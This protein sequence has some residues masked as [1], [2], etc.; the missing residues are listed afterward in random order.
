MAIDSESAGYIEE[1]G[2]RLRAEVGRS[3]VGVYLHGSA[4]LGGFV[5]ARSDVD[6]LAVT[7]TGLTEEAKRGVSEALSPASLPCPAA[8]LEFSAVTVESA[9]HPVPAPSFELHLATSADSMRM[10]DG[11]MHPG[12]PDLVLHFAVCMRHGQTI[13][14][15]PPPSLVFGPIPT[16]WLLDRLGE[17]LKWAEQ[18]ASV[19][20]QV[21]NACR[22]WRFTTEHRWCSKIEGGRWARERV[23][24]PAVIDNALARQQGTPAWS[25]PDPD[26]LEVAALTRHALEQ[27]R[28]AHELDKDG[29]FQAS[30]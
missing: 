16:A 1:V 22:A 25:L 9:L 13:G 27:L 23:Q 12:D 10:V 18:H 20:Y 29:L 30:E 19:E 28:R 17:E 14:D 3:L 26:P 8:G 24:D 6:L 15:G 7:S 2:A 11:H 5:R 4:V 21:L